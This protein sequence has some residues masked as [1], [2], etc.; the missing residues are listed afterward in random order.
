LKMIEGV[1]LSFEPGENAIPHL[2]KMTICQSLNPSYGVITPLEN[3]R[4]YRSIIII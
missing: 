2:S 4:S 3:T 1:V